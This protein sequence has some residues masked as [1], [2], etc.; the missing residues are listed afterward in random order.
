M[1]RKLRGPIESSRV[2]KLHSKTLERERE[3]EGRKRKRE[4]ERNFRTQRNIR[5]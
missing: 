1:S 4:R 2:G 3:K 5:T